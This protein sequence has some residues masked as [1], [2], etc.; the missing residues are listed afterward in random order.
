M[1]Q[2]SIKEYLAK[3]EDRI[4]RM[5]DTNDILKNMRSDLRLIRNILL[6]IFIN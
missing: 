4:R 3:L 6:L 5:K 1:D 2:Q